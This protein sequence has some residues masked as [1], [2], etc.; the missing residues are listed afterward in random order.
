[1]IE[2]LHPLRAAT[3]FKSHVRRT[4]MEDA[5][6]AAVS[7][8]SRFEGC[9]NVVAIGIMALVSLLFAIP[10]LLELMP[11]TRD[12]PGQPE[13]APFEARYAGFMPHVPD[14]PD[15]YRASKYNFGMTVQI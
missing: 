8:P 4:H 13:R 5:S 11:T 9:F 7:R 1:M 3:I 15:L 12:A 6:N 2:H 14:R 10:L